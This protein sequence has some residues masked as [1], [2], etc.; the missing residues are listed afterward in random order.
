[1][2]LHP[3]HHFSEKDVLCLRLAKQ[4]VKL[5][6]GLCLGKNIIEP[7]VLFKKPLLGILIVDIASL[8]RLVLIMEPL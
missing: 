3:F 8:F 2:C 7:L 6:G 1:M 4:I 5:D